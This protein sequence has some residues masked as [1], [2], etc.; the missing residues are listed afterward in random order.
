MLGIAGSKGIVRSEGFTLDIRT[1]ELRDANGRA[2]RL[3]EQPLQLLIALLERP[4]E[5][6]LREDLRKP[7]IPEL[8]RSREDQPLWRCALPVGSD[9]VITA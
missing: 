3:S 5:L 4:G 7:A 8:T 6:V 9:H 2:V 1:G